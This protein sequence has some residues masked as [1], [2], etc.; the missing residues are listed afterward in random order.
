MRCFTEADKVCQMRTTI[1]LLISSSIIFGCSTNPVDDWAQVKPGMDKH[2]VLEI[3]GN[4]T[5]TQRLRGNDRW[6]YVFYDQNSKKSKV[7]EFSDGAATYVGDKPS[8][9][10]SAEDQDVINET[11]N[12]ALTKKLQKQREEADKALEDFEKAN[13]PGADSTVPQYEPVR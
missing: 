12:A 2:E 8:P 6:T 9:V 1:A 4:P 5:R 7:V 13:T 10:I 3:M 11:T